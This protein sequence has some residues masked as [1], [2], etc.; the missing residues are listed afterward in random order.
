M[1]VSDNIVVNNSVGDTSSK[2]LSPWGKS[3]PVAPCSLASVMDEEIAK[4]LQAKEDYLAGYHLQVDKASSA[5]A[6]EGDELTLRVN[7]LDMGKIGLS[8]CDIHL[9]RIP[10]HSYFLSLFHAN[11]ECSL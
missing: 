5:N 1:E 3:P 9:P 7:L 8:S 2:K 11:V 10:L 4:E 6:F